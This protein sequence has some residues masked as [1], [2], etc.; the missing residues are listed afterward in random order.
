M[1]RR[2]D[3]LSCG[4]RAAL[5]LPCNELSTSA[6]VPR[7]RSH[8]RCTGTPSMS[9]GLLRF[10][11][12][13]ENWVYTFMPQQEVDALLSCQSHRLRQAV[14]KPYVAIHLSLIPIMPCRPTRRSWT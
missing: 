8:W 10:S 2:W 6:A 5:A 4:G 11:P 3:E 9:F 7:Q 12:G 14:Q 1:K 13:G